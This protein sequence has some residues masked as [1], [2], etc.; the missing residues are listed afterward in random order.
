MIA[1]RLLGIGNVAAGV[2]FLPLDA[3]SPI[4]LCEA[5]RTQQTTPFIPL[6]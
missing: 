1:L 4:R 6:F 2:A 5:K 3:G